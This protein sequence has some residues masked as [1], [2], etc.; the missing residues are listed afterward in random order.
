MWIPTLVS[1][2]KTAHLS[3]F[4]LLGYRYAA[5]PSGRFIGRDI[6]G[7]FFLAN[8]SKPRRGVLSSA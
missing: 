4:H 8:A 7:N 3:L 5:F 6:V 2:I 1:L